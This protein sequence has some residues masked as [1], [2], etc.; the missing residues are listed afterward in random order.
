MKRLWRSWVELWDRE[1]SPAALAIVRIL[2]GVCLVADLLDLASLGIVGPMFSAAPDGYA[3]PETDLAR[4]LVEHGLGPTVWLVA[5]IAAFC[6]AFGFATRVACV[7]QILASAQ[8]AHICPDSDRGIQ[9]ILRI[10]LA[11]LALSQCHARWSVDAWLWK[12]LGRPFP[13]RVPAWPRYLLLLQLLWI[14][15]SAGIHK[16]GPEWGPSGGFLA[17][18]NSIADPH[19]GRFD[20]GWLEAALPLTRIATAATLAFEVTAPL[21]LVW[22]YCA[23]TAD[24]P[25]RLRRWINK[26]RIRWIWIGLGAGFHLGLVITMPIGIFPWGMLALYPVLLRPKELS[27]L[28]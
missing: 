28:Q 20:P 22:L 6:V 4:T 14:Y 24:R 17:V 13:E 27:Y 5:L 12:K 10:V 3:M 9:M 11:I 26:L 7:L 25:G 16:S 15:F 19:F 8:L 18:A 2:V 23:E 21:Y 1:E